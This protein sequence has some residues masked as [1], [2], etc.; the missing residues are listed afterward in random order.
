MIKQERLLKTFLDMVKIESPS[1][2]EENIKEWIVKYLTK[3]GITAVC[4]AHGNIVA[5]IEG[6]GSKYF[7]LNAHMDTVQPCN[8]IKP[9]V[10]DGIISTESE[11]I[12]GAD[13]KAGIA[14]ILEL[15][16]VLKENQ[17]K[18]HPLEIVFTVQEELGMIGVQKLNYSLIDARIGVTIDGGNINDIVMGAPYITNIDIAIRGKAAH[19]GIEP[20]KGINAL[21]ASSE[22]IAKFKLGRID[23][24]TTANIG[25]IKGGSIRNSVPELVE[26]KAEVRSHNFSKMNKYILKMKNLFEASAKKYKAH[27]DFNTELVSH[28]YKFQKSSNQIKKITQA[29]KNQKLR[30]Q[31]ILS[32]GGSDANTF[33]AHNIKVVNVGTGAKNVHTTNESISV[34]DLTKIPNILFELIKI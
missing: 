18:H 32:G 25:T 11:T 29:L 33:H 34:E 27:L 10:K 22:A 4:D 5:K 17:I 1:G 2:K 30:P 16:S 20:E 15:I 12:L 7:I 26:L 21:K 6:V 8:D 9:I 19:S 23:K 3:L 24:A 13:D 31:Y 14:A 28:G